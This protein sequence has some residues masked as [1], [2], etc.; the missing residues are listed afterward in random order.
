MAPM[1][2]TASKTTASF[3]E[4]KKRKTGLRCQ[5]GREAEEGAAMMVS[6]HFPREVRWVQ[7]RFAPFP[8]RKQGVEDENEGSGAQLL[9]SSAARKAFKWIAKPGA[10]KASSVRTSWKS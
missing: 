3:S 7:R 8:A 6:G 1:I 9:L 2:S 10:S 4:E 5:P